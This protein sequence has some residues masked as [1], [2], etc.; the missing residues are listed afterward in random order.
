[1]RAQGLDGGYRTC[2]TVLMIER[3]VT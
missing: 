2:S 3:P 1:V